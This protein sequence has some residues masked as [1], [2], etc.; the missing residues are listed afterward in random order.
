MV[1]WLDWVA[2]ALSLVLPAF[3]MHGRGIADGMISLIGLIFLMRSALTGQWK[4]VRTPWLMVGW[5]WGFGAIIALRF[6]YKP[7]F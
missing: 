5:V 4:W 3:V 1:M 6:G 7:P 2:L